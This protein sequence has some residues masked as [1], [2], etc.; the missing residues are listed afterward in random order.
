MA[1]SGEVQTAILNK[2]TQTLEKD[3]APLTGLQLAEAYAW[4]RNPNQ[5]HGGGVSPKASN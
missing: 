3:W 4:V 5:S 1:D 2:I